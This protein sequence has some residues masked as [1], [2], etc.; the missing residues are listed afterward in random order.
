MNDAQRC[1]GTTREQA[2]RKTLS[3]RRSF[4]RPTLRESTFTWRRSTTTSISSSRSAL[5]RADPIARRNNTY[6]RANSMAGRCYVGAGQSDELEKTYPSDLRRAHLLT[7]DQ[8]LRRLAL[9][10]WP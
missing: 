5:G 2:A 4:G 7:G 10:I 9:R 6:R 8:V 3:I 1:L